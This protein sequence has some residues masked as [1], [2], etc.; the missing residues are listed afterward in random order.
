MRWRI[1][2]HLFLQIPPYRNVMN[3][4]VVKWWYAFCICGQNISHEECDADRWIPNNQPTIIGQGICNATG[5]PW[6]PI[7]QMRKAHAGGKRLRCHQRSAQV[8]WDKIWCNMNEA[9]LEGENGCMERT[10][11]PKIP[12]SITVLRSQVSTVQ[13][14]A[15]LW[16]GF[17]TR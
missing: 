15:L 9:C 13:F 16:G 14:V 12:Q 17:I 11:N 4:K 7:V 10:R 8:W 3:E 6:E 2:K 1:Y 5:V